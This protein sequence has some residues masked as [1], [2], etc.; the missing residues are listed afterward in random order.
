MGSREPIAPRKSTKRPQRR[1][2]MHVGIGRGKAMTKVYMEAL[3]R[4]SRRMALNKWWQRFPI[5]HNLNAPP[6]P[7]P[8]QRVT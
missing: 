6:H 4:S 8:A 2:F 5:T 7:P 1:D 3:S